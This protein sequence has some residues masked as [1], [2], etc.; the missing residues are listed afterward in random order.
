VLGPKVARESARPDPRGW[1]AARV[2]TSGVMSEHPL[3]DPVFIDAVAR[4]VVE[5]LGSGPTSSDDRASDLLTVAEVATRYRVRPSWVYAHQRE[6]GV[7]RLG[8]GPK[9]R[10]RFSSEVVASRLQGQRSVRS[11]H[12]AHRPRRRARRRLRSR[13]PPPLP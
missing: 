13:T 6:L 5:L 3:D 10:L 9:A 8:A 4:R 7:V 1:N 11:S 2:T 12:A